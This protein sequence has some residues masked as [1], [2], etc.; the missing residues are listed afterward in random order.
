MT[1]LGFVG[2][3]QMGKGMA[4]NLLAAGHP[5]TVNDLDAAAGEELV[6]AGAVWADSPAEA[7]GACE[8]LFTSLPTPAVIEAVAYAGGVVDSLSAG[9]AWFDLSTN[10][11]DLVRRLHRDLRER[12]ADFLDAPVSG[13]PAGA[14]SGELAVWVGGD[15]EVFERRG[16]LLT[17]FADRSRRVG[18]VSAGTTAKLLHNTVSATVHA[19]VAEVMSVGVK[20]GI[21]PADLFETLRSGAA[22]RRRTFDAVIPRF[23]AGRFEPAS[24]QLQ[25]AHKDLGLAR[26]LAQDVGVPT[27]LCD[28]VFDELSEAMNRGWAERDAQSFMTLQQERAGIAPIE[29]PSEVLDGIRDRT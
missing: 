24:F 3:G 19:A 10:S 13:G 25:L 27:R 18:G 15:A 17:A 2:L 14:R 28:L 1:R 20:A 7:A 4:A 26:R 9:A 22:G 5:L 12:G 21:E 8:V 6:E 29:I 11:L 16:H 23:L